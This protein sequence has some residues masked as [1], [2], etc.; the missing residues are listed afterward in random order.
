MMALSYSDPRAEAYYSQTS[1]LLMSRDSLS[2][3]QTL[4][5]HPRLMES[6]ASSLQSPQVIQMYMHIWEKL[7]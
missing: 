6:E 1:N 5:L 4:K 2:E 7:V 3:M